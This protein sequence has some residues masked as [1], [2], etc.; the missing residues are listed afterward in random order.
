MNLQTRTTF[1]LAL[2]AAADRN[3]QTLTPEAPKPSEFHRESR[4]RDFG[5]G[6]GRSSGYASSRRYTSNWGNARFEFC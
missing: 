6:Y 1:S 5:T 4:A 2:V 3:R